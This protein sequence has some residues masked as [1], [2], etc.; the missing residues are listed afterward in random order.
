MVSKN[1]A[2]V[3]LFVAAF[4]QATVTTLP[5][6]LATLLVVNV[7][8]KN[9]WIFA[10]ALVGGLLLDTAAVRTLGQT[11]LFLISFL[12]L[13]SF[14]EKKFE[15]NT[16]PF[17]LF[18]TFAGSTLFLYIFDTNIFLLPSLISTA[19]AAILFLLLR[20]LHPRKEK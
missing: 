15:I 19:F 3:C 9:M 1:I 18:S 17:I 13:V 8:E 20:I 11:S 6:F 14:Y 7:L 12:A 2:I 5:L 16:L 4:L 10:A